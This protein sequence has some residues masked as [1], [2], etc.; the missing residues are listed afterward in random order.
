MR[1]NLKTTASLL[2]SSVM[3][4]LVGCASSGPEQVVEMGPIAY[5]PPPDIPRY[6]F[7]R[8]LMGTADVKERGD[9]A[10]FK[11]ML[12]GKNEYEGQGF[13]KPFDIAVHQGRVF[14]SDTVNKSLFALDFVEKIT[15]FVGK[16]GTD[17]DIQH[18][19]GLAVD[20][21]GNLYAIDNKSKTVRVYT[22]DGQFIKNVGNSSEM[23]KP[24]GLDVTA[25]GKTLFVVDV[26]GVLSD[27][28]KIHVYDVASGDL[29]RQIGSRGSSEGELNLPRDVEIAPNGLLYV[30]DGGNFRIQVFT[31][32]G[33]FVRA[34]GEAGSFPGQFSRPKGIAVDAD[35]NV[36]VVDAAF[37]NFQIFSDE[38]K[39]LMAI[40]NRSTQNA[41]GNYMLNAG[42]DIDEDG[43]VYVAGQFFRKVEVFRPAALKDDEGF[44]G[45]SK[46]DKKK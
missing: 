22:R 41:P 1:I 45:K 9:T 32:E 27:N 17:N 29:I 35:N 4:T 18:P 34:W 8:M 39:L 16:D 11:A 44:F 6:Y 24:T 43:R 26:G 46:K 38:G 36:Y 37:G 23:S 28:H 42:I 14:I 12:T 21:A 40:G 31:Q 25:D 20:K 3:L 10:L 19:Q 13:S 30:T 5:P 2:I 7:E 15:F 33:D